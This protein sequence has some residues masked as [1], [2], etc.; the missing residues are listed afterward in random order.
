V[1]LTAFYYPLKLIYKHYTPDGV[2][3]PAP[4]PFR[5]DLALQLDPDDRLLAVSPVLFILFILIILFI[6]VNFFS[7]FSVFSVFRG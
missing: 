6:D 3:A 7:L 2:K 5:Q 1:R 4:D